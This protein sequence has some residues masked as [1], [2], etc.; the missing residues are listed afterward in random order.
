MTTD[1]IKDNKTKLKER[2][3][4]RADYNVVMYNDHYTTYAYVES[5]LERHF[6]KSH[7]EAVQLTK[8][9]DT[10][11]KAIAGTYSRDVAEEKAAEAGKDAKAHGHAFMLHVEPA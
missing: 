7:D 11:G 4:K 2:L 8:E 5:L 1:T 10:K 9:V 3:D 6:R